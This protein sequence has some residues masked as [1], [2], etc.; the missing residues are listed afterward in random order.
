M[1]SYHVLTIGFKFI[2]NKLLLENSLIPEDVIEVDYL[3][4]IQC[5]SDFRNRPGRVF[6]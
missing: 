3:S 6:Q 2:K 1:N 5:I 4:K